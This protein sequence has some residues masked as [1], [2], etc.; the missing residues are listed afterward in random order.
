MLSPV[1]ISPVHF[2]LTT[3]TSSHPTTY[4]THTIQT[5][6]P[7]LIAN[8]HHDTRTREGIASPHPR[9]FTRRPKEQLSSSRRRFNMFKTSAVD[10]YSGV[11]G[12][13]IDCVG[14]CTGEKEYEEENGAFSQSGVMAEAVQVAD[15][16]RTLAPIPPPSFSTACTLHASDSGLKDAEMEVD[17]VDAYFENRPIQMNVSLLDSITLEVPGCVP[18]V[19]NDPYAPQAVSEHVFTSVDVAF[20]VF[21]SA[22]TDKDTTLNGKPTSN[23]CSIELPTTEDHSIHIPKK[24]AESDE[25]RLSS[26]TSGDEEEVSVNQQA[27][28]S[29]MGHDLQPV[30]LFDSE[31]ELGYVGTTQCT[32]RD[33]V[34]PEPTSNWNELP[35]FVHPQDTVLIEEPKI[36]QEGLSESG[37]LD[38]SFAQG[39]L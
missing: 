18:R 4:T 5:T 19:F 15:L 29:I 6:M 31:E 13:F 14:C 16:C 24:V 10:A 25:I 11:V 26:L 23:A 1:P 22:T 32:T 38:A 12:A 21:D 27:D 36:I 30:S 39:L 8:D 37:S 35:F 17:I 28:L 33:L 3:T 34:A 7:S 2:L 9:F 20:A